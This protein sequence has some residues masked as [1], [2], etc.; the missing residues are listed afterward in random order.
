MPIN[1]KCTLIEPDLDTFEH[2]QKTRIAIAN[3]GVAKASSTSGHELGIRTKPRERGDNRAC[4]D[5]VTDLTNVIIL[6]VRV[7]YYCSREHC[8]EKL[9]NPSM[10]PLTT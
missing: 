10:I 6:R 3:T 1:F 8:H 4:D 2:N 7:A 5:T 9:H